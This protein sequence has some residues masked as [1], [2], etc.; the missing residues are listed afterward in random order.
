MKEKGREVLKHPFIAS[1]DVAFLPHPLSLPLG[2][3][4]RAP[5]IVQFA[6]LFLP[7]ILIVNLIFCLAGEGF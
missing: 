4:R 2:E 1:A 6:R 5:L 3:G 7:Q